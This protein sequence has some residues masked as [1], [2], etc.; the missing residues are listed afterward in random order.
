MSL[1]EKLFSI[2]GICYITGLALA[3][4]F[5][6]EIRQLPYLLPLSCI[7][8]AVNMGMLYVVFKDIFNRRFAHTYSKYLWVVL[9]FLF[10]PAIIIY[11]PMH[12]FQRR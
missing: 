9:I 1:S 10:I 7:G 6:Q 12:G 4:V 3:L 8:V 5:S 11:L 2:F